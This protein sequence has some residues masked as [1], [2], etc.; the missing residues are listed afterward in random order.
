MN[1]IE[2]GETSVNY[3]AITH[4]SGLKKANFKCG[5]KVVMVNDNR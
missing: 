2:I 5:H 1:A 4:I 3:C